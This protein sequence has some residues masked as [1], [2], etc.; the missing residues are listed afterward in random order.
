MRVTV[1]IPTYG[2]ERIGD[3]F[4]SVDS[5]LGQADADVE[6]IV[7]A[8]E[9]EELLRMLREKY[10]DKITLAPNKEKGLSKARNLGTKLATGEVVA[11]I[12]DD[13]VAC[14]GWIAAIRHGFSGRPEAGAMTGQIEPEWTNG[15]AAWFARELYWMISCTYDE[16]EDGAEV[17]TVI[18]TNMAVRK[19]LLVE[20]GGF[21]DR[22]GAVQ[23]WKRERGIWV[24]RCGVVGEERELCMR[25]GST[26]K[27]N[28]YAKGMQVRHKVYPYRIAVKNLLKRGYWE[29]YSKDLLKGQYKGDGE[30]LSMEMDYGIRLIRNYFR[31]GLGCGSACRCRQYATTLSVMASVGLGYAAYKLGAGR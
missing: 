5:V 26:G 15:Q 21:S 1:V 29:G 22:L 10:R 23:K 31:S 3:T 20:L 9:N 6:I 13:A 16:V 4:Q 24:Q 25:I 11:F 7:V 8:D 12:D 2:I 18:G 19:E 17:P 27:K 30:A 14:A 28:I